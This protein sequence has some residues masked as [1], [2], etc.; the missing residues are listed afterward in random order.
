MAR[1]EYD[2]VIS[3]CD[4]GFVVRIG[5]KTLVFSDDNAGEM[6]ADLSRYLTGRG[7]GYHEMYSKYFGES[8][9]EAG[10]TGRAECEPMPV[11]NER[12]RDVPPP[13]LYRN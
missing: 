4:N 3:G 7:D 13:P 8:P 5:C 10:Q 2:V 6:I 11:C 9:A 1:T 12:L